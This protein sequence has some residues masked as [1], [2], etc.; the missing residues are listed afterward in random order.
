[1]TDQGARGQEARVTTRDSWAEASEGVL[2]RVLKIREAFG[3]IAAHQHKIL[4]ELIQ[5]E[6]KRADK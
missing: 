4:L 2:P 3:R 6:E 5:K 1:M